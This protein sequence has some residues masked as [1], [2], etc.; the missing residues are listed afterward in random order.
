LP[1]FGAGWSADRTRIAVGAVQKYAGEVYTMSANGGDVRVIQ[2]DY[3][4]TRPVYSPDNRQLAYL[5]H[6]GV[7]TGPGGWSLVVENTDGSGERTLTDGKVGL[8][9]WGT[10]SW[11]RD[12]QRLVFSG[13][14]LNNSTTTVVGPAS[15]PSDPHIYSIAR[16]GSDLRKLPI[17]GDDPTVSLDDERVAFVV[18]YGVAPGLYVADKDGSAARLIVPGA[19]VRH[20]T[21]SPDNTRLMFVSGRDGSPTC[22]GCDPPTS[23]YAVNADGSNRVRITTPPP[24]QSD[25]APAWAT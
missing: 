15:Q 9:D 14:D 17:A 23:I 10:A 5:E 19:D 4:S 6:G 13:Y 1:V 24:N 18:R 12:G 21:W 25:G 20:P 22:Q 3:A 2:P 8:E 16:D 11:T 7:I